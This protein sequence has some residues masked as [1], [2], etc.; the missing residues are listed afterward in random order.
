MR[1][2]ATSVTGGLSGWRGSKALSLA[3]DTS[4]TTISKGQTDR[5][6]VRGGGGCHALGGL[7]SQGSGCR[8]ALPV[9]PPLPAQLQE[10]GDR[11]HAAANNKATLEIDWRCT[12]EA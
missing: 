5:S 10:S 1:P 8:L 7:E 6:Q 12:H 11:A 4:T 2:Y 9:P 3:T